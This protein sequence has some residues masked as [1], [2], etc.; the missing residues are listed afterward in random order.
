MKAETMSVYGISKSG[1]DML[2]KNSALELGP[3]GIRVNSVK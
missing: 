1:L 3:K 2:T